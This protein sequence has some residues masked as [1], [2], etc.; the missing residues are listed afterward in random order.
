MASIM[1]PGMTPPSQMASLNP[2]K[3]QAPTPP[4]APSLYGGV[5]TVSSP[6]STATIPYQSA[7]SVAPLTVSPLGTPT[8]AEYFAANPSQQARKQFS[9]GGTIQNILNAVAAGSLGAAGGLKGNPGLGAEYV[10]QG[11]ARDAQVPEVNASRYQQ[12]VIQ[13]LKDSAAL[14]DTQSQIEERK[15]LAAKGLSLA[16]AVAPFTMTRE[17]AVAINHPELAGTQTTARDYSKALIG[18]GNNNTSTGNNTRTNE[19]KV[20]TTGMNNATSTANNTASNATR[21]EIS[22]AAD[23]TKVLVANMHDATSRANNANT[24]DHKGTTGAGGF[25]VPADVTK[26]AALASNVLENADAVEGLLNKRPDIIGA[27][28]GRYSNVQQMIGSNDPDIQALG[29]RMHN[30]AL[31]SN[32]AHGVRAQQAIQKTEDELF[33]NFKAGPDAIK[34]ALNATRGSMQT[35]LNDEQNFAT[36][37]RRTGGTNNMV[38]PTQGIPAAAAAQLQE[39]VQHTFGNGQVWTKQNGKPVRVK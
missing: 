23:K 25:K 29:V 20:T 10:Q 16:D 6:Q 24:N 3:K 27:A 1:P 33:S 18:A 31:A 17:Q 15:A 21:K 28:G 12:A 7:K 39:G 34:G 5:D 26:R 9:G 14:A 2:P 11:A 13:P 32:G 8:E 37:G 19:T 36:T 30:I 4:P 22:D 38:P 35:F